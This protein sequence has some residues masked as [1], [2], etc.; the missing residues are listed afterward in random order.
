MDNNAS[1][2]ISE[3]GII[4]SRIINKRKLKEEFIKD[5]DEDVDVLEVTGNSVEELERRI[6]EFEEYYYIK[7]LDKNIVK[8]GDRYNCIIKYYRK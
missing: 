3:T 1:G 2:I 7:V 8:H 5:S 6:K 4:F